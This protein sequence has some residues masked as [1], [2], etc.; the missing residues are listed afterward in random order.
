MLLFFPF[1]MIE[2]N[3]CGQ[4]ILQYN[5]IAWRMNLI[6]VSAMKYGIVLLLFFYHL[7]FGEAKFTNALIDMQSPYLLQH[8]HNP[9]NWYPWSEE[10]SGRAEKE[11]KLIFLSIGYSTCHWC[12]VMEE[13]SFENEKIA[14]LLNK[15]FISIKVDKEEMP[16]IDSHYQHIHSLLQKGRNGW[17]LTVIMTPKKEILFIGTYLP[18]KDDYGI[19]GMEK[20]LPKL[21]F[22]YQTDKDRTAKIIA[23]NQTLIDANRISPSVVANANLTKG[24]VER[25]VKRYDPIY[26]GFDLRPRFPLASHLR[27]LL[28]VYQLEQDAKVFEMVDT[29]LD[30]MAKGGIYDQVEGGFFRYST[31][32]DWM[33][34][35][36]EKMLYTNAELIPVYTK[37][38]LITNN[39]RYRSVVEESIDMVT[40]RFGSDG[41]YY[42]ASD[43][44]TD[45]EE[46]RYFV[47]R[48]DEVEQALRHKGYTPFE[49]KKNL[50]YYDISS[51]GNF[52]KGLSQPH[53]NTDIKVQPKRFLQT[54]KVLQELRQNRKYPFVDKKIITSWNAMMITALYKA[55][56][57]DPKYG[58]Q[59][60]Q[61]LEALLKKHLIDGVLYHQ[62]ID[63]NQP[64]QP[65]LLED[66]AY[67]AEALA[68][69]Y[70]STYNADYLA[71]AK[72]LLSKGRKKFFVDGVWHLDDS[73]FQAKAYYED[74]YYTAPLA[75]FLHAMLSVG[76]LTYD[77]D[78]IEATKVHIAKEK[79]AILD[80]FDRSPEALRLLA[81]LQYGD[82]I[83]KSSPANLVS[84]QTH[85]NKIRYPFV[86]QAS[87]DSD[88]YTVCN[89]KSCIADDANL[90]KIIKK[91]R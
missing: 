54:K 7:A 23:A 57:V 45:G 53:T 77:V 76:F 81:R 86:L 36:F 8:A 49:I 68:A 48:Y 83:L 50:Q 58:R 52:E 74:R 78:L 71:L 43:A 61:S 4:K 30:S 33:I 90:S 64:A 6:G 67:L 85:I 60:T 1:A 91:I 79:N 73:A 62:S 22:L 17:P 13:E 88:L 42:S 41:L 82:F 35:H 3:Q 84:G 29:I 31:D 87:E 72:E 2:I 44:D 47:Y 59:A 66:Y 5:C 27:F 55:A 37:M 51:D 69:A 18:P 10:I 14:S 89:E 65:A 56:T 15:D 16:H 9:V 24:F 32:V 26:K 34:P 70:Q 38:Y 63:F 28:E 20:L 12:H 25:M 46:G 21:A 11:D 75:K 40:R 39:P 19:E 80:A